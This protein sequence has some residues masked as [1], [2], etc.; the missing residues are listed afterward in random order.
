MTMAS[1]GDTLTM[2]D[3]TSFA[4]VESAA[5][6]AGERIEFEIMMAPGAQGPPKHFH[7]SLLGRALGWQPGSR[8]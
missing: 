4:I 6:S 7:R 1:T 2:P 8:G 3:G 5:D